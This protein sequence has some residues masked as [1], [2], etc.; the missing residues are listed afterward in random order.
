MTVTTV[1]GTS[2]GKPSTKKVVAKT[3]RFPGIL[4]K[5]SN[6]KPAK[7]VPSKQLKSSGAKKSAFPK[8]KI[9]PTQGAKKLIG[10]N[11]AKFKTAKGAKSS[12]ALKGPLEKQKINAPTEKFTFKKAKAGGNVK[13]TTPRANLKQFKKQVK[14]AQRD[15][16]GK[17]S[18]KAIG[19]K[20]T[21]PVLVSKKASIAN[22]DVRSLEF[23]V[24]R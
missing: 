15:G 21:K 7:L 11:G 13:F 5:D 3:P 18:M 14:Q 17:A 8:F 4:V 6:G 10:K 9:A 12:V 2:D 19:K 22:S 20:G 23:A 16:N 24:K 1:A